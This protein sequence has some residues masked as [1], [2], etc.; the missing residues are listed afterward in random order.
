MNTSL[1]KKITIVGN[2]Q[3]P[4][5]AKLLRGCS[6]DG[7]EINSFLLHRY[8]IDHLDALL[9][10]DEVVVLSMPFAQIKGNPKF[11]SNDLLD[12]YSNC[13]IHM[14]S[15]AYFEG[16]HP[17]WGYFYS[18]NGKKIYPDWDD[19]INYWIVFKYLKNRVDDLKSPFSLEDSLSDIQLDGVWSRS[20]AELARREKA[21]SS[22]TNISSYLDDSA[23]HK[24]WF[25]TFNHPSRHI[26]N[27]LVNQILAYF[28]LNS[29]S[30]SQS[31][32]GHDF[33]SETKIPIHSNFSADKKSDAAAPCFIF[34]KVAY[35]WS[36]VVSMHIDFLSRQSSADILYSL[37]HYLQSRPEL[38]LA[39]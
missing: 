12:R 26:F 21:S 1:P 10:D 6:L 36:E 33:L 17:Y 14:I 30:V 25:W 3:A 35:T 19:Y 39:I 34:K 18:S 11:T 38:N 13:N 37:D 15:N 32:P 2:C 4:V 24:H 23:Q 22:I 8:A 31:W 9:K 5:I 27:I 29:N 28:E 20:R 16:Y 7:F